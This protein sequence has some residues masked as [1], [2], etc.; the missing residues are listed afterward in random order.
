MSSRSA[1]GR[2]TTVTGRAAILAVVL[3]G[4]LVTLAY[5]ARE[6]LAQRVQIAALH[7]QVD[8]QQRRVDALGAAAARWS[9]PAYVEAQARERLHFV[10]PGQTQFLVL[11][12][13]VGAK[14][15]AASGAGGA[16]VAT[17]TPAG[18][19]AWFDRLWHSVQVAGLP[20]SEQPAARPST[21]ATVR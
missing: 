18:G 11:G 21:G 7:A 9:D 15:G 3:C 6:L 20:V 1:P 17:P 2:R 13:A 4:V 10:M 8:A 12:P 16:K 5:P 19:D 14:P